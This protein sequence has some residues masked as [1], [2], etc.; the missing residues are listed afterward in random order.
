MR[1]GGWLLVAL[2][3]LVLI[4]ASA[5]FGFS[6]HMGIVAAAALAVM[7]VTLRKADDAQLAG[8]PFARQPDE[9][10]QFIRINIS[11]DSDTFPCPTGLNRERSSL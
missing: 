3:A 10:R 11:R 1:S 6:V 5:D 7:V 9:T 4:A 8:L 2:A